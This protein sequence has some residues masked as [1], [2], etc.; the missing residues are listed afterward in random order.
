[1]PLVATTLKPIDCRARDRLDDEGLVVV[2]D[3]D[4]HAA[5]G[6]HLDAAAEL[7]LGEGAGEGGSMSASPSRFQSSP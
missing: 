4:E 5:F 2:L 6:R 1:V 3:R 7:G